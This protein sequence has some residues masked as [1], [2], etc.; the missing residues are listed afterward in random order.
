MELGWLL[1]CV[2]R[3]ARLLQKRVP[4]VSAFVGGST[5]GD[6]FCRYAPELAS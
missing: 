2:S 3:G 1:A 5:R 6:A 4:R